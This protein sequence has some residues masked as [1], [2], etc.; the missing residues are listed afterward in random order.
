MTDQL[1]SAIAITRAM[2][3]ELE[4]ELRRDRDFLTQ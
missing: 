2:I 4:V 3:T 1:Q